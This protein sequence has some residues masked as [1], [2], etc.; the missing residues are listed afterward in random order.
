MTWSGFL[1]LRLNGLSF[2]LAM[3][4]WHSGIEVK[5]LVAKL[6]EVEF[7]AAKPETDSLEK[8]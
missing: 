2:E 5:C 8:R 4:N 6:I 3:A 1:E 7:L